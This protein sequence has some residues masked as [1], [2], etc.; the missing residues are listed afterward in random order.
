MNPTLAFVCLKVATNKQADSTEFKA[1][2]DSGC[3]TTTMGT[4]TFMKLSDSNKINIMQPKKTIM[5]QSC[6]GELTATQGL[7]DLCL[8]FNGA[9]GQSLLIQ[10]KVIIYD[11][12]QF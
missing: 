10:H 11:K 7:A 6:T 3:A 2:H 8:Q 9:N 12:N 5:V 1:L 4:Q